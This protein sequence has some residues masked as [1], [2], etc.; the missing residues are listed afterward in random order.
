M[1]L[2][3]I[4][5][6]IHLLDPCHDTS[7]ALME[8]AQILGHEVWITQVN[9]LSVVDGK[10]WAILQQVELVPID[11]VEG[12]WVAANPWYRLQERSLISLETMDAV[13]MRTDP[14]VNDSYLFATYILDYVDQNKTLVINNP[15]GIRRANEKMYAL[16]FKEVIPETIVSADKQLIRQFVE[17]K[18][19]TVLKPLG[20]KAGEGILFLQAGD[21]N[22]NSIV[23]LSTHQGK[24]P[25]MVQTY[26][27]EA[28]DGDKRIIL[29]H[30]EPIGALNR[31]S[32][33]SDFRNNMAAGGTV[34]ETEI[35][36]REHEICT[37]L[38]DKLRQDG[39]IFVGI[40]V[41]GGYLTEVN[42][43]SP[44]GVREIDRL[45][46]TRLGHQVIQWVEQRLQAKK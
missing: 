23:E 2:A 6:P 3:F 10:A 35:T 36:P 21:R 41:I 19:A 5:D 12:R 20:N 8:A 25:V 42:V 24:L 30:G 4:I 11:L 16:Q 40:D 22:F 14:P 33:G 38:A 43:T 13:F 28:K 7:V 37:R 27:P 17:A 45:S 31:L 46:G 44:T 29:L 1:K 9:W 15:D 34:A 39:L 32:S 26:L 18:G